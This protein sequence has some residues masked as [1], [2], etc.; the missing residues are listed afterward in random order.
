MKSLSGVLL[1]LGSMYLNL[2]HDLA[3]PVSVFLVF[4][5]F[6]I[7]VLSNDADVI[8]IIEEDSNG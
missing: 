8:V 7:L 3:D 6:V 1:I 2:A 5:G 4:L